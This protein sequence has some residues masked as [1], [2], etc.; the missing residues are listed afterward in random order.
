[1]NKTTGENDPVEALHRALIAAFGENWSIDDFQPDPQPGQ[2][3]EETRATTAEVLAR[4]RAEHGEPT[5]E[6]L[7]DAEAR[8]RALFD[9]ADARLRERSTE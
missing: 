4:W 5:A 2:N 1:M 6:E 3:S 9:R 8:V 7:T